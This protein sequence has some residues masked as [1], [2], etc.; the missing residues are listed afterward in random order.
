V[1]MPPAVDLQVWLETGPSRR[2]PVLD[3]ANDSG[4]CRPAN[5]QSR[6]VVEFAA[7]EAEEPGVWTVSLAKD[8]SLAAAIQVMVTFT[9]L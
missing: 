6:C 8:S 3:T 7:L 2:V 4:S 1:T 9:R 5:R